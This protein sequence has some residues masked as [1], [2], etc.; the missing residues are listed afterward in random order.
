MIHQQH[1]LNCRGRLL[2]LERPAVMGILNITP[3]SFHD[4][5]RYLDPELA[6]N[7]AGEMLAEGAAIIDIGAASSRP[8]AA[9]IPEGE[10][11]DR[12]LPVLEAV[13]KSFP[14]AILSVDTTRSAVARS[15]I[16]AGASVINDISGGAADPGI[17]EICRQYQAPFICMHMQGSPQ[18]MQ[19]RPQY[20][21]VAG[22]VLRYFVERLRVLR[23]AGVVDVL[24]DPGF[25]F[26]KDVGHNYTLLAKLGI[27]KF[28]EVPI[29]VGL[30]RKSMICKVLGL[31]PADALNGTT[32]L[33]M[34]ALERGARILRAHDVQEAVEVIRLFDYYRS[35]QTD[36]KAP[37]KL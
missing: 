27:F 35:V 28:L 24:I 25:G 4:G 6:V 22:E 32:A 12:L 19:V 13:I 20:Q 29:V 9:D 3:D 17:I 2:R 14:D 33:H 10:E 23:A 8:G 15:A 18:T 34:L 36:Q 30:S 11:T 1:T 16:E 31:A 21:D 37:G 26:G 7:R 5:G